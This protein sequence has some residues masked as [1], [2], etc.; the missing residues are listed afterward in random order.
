MLS[1]RVPV[2]DQTVGNQ[3]SAACAAEHDPE[4]AGR[5]MTGQAG[6]PARSAIS[7]HSMLAQHAAI[8]LSRLVCG[9]LAHKNRFPRRRNIYKR[10]VSVLNGNRGE[11]VC[12]ATAT[13]AN[14]LFD[15]EP[16]PYGG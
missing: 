5:M 11:M 8:C 2:P 7:E 15:R 12:S 4:P 9:A 10:D 16:E 1:C 13:A 6:T 14:L 3:D